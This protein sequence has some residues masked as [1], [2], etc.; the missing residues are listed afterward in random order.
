MIILAA[1]YADRQDNKNG[2]LI[3]L[4]ANGQ[5]ATAVTS[6]MVAQPDLP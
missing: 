5:F 3:A 2:R 1:A 4:D 6:L